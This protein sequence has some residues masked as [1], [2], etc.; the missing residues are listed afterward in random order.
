MKGKRL[1]GVVYWYYVIH[2]ISTLWIDRPISGNSLL[3]PHLQEKEKNKT[4]I[5]GL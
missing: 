4:C 5:S 1:H 2:L 3:A